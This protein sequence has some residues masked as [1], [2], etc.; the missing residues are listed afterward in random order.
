MGVKSIV[1]KKCTSY[2]IKF[3]CD[4]FELMRGICWELLIKKL[5][6][7]KSSALT[8]HSQIANGPWNCVTCLLGTYL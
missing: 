7:F 1:K 8:I 4:V 5:S 6:V 2:L 3:G